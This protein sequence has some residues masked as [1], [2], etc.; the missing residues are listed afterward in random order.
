M[1]RIPRF[2]ILAALTSLASAR[3]TE[4]RNPY[5]NELRGFKF[6]VKYLRRLTPYVSDHEEVVRV[7]GGSAQVIAAGSWQIL[8][9]YVGTGNTVNGH[10]W[11]HD[12]SGRLESIEITPKQRVSMLHVK[13]PA[14]FTHSW[15]SVS[16]INVECDVYRDKFGLAYWIFSEDSSVG[17]K[18]D[19]M[20]I[21]YGPSERLS[22]QI[23][24]P[25]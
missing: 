8:P 25:N 14:A 17:K 3:A 20:E 12:I 6:Y 18:G 9:L 22:R 2:L 10:A 13:F 5:P 11:A 16:E 1:R 24:G 23:V 7:L 15:G 19:L 21:S 4:L